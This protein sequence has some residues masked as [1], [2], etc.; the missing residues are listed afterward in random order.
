MNRPLSK[1]LATWILLTISRTLWGLP[2]GL[3][4]VIVDRLGA[5]GAIRWIVKNLPRYERMLKD[6]GPIR[7]H[8][9][10]AFVSM[11]NGCYYCAFAHARAFE[12][13]FFKARGALFPLDEH[14]MV[15]LIVLPD[16]ELLA[17]LDAAFGSAQLAEGPAL[18][19]RLVELMFR[20]AEGAGAEDGYLLHTI[21]MFE[22]LNFCGISTAVPLD[23]AHDPINKDHDLKARYAQARLTSPPP[24]EEKPAA[25]SG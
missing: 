12:L 19:R 20:G 4:P 21:R 13:H 9:A 24:A 16:P 3:M 15:D 8:L 22:V 7:G 5:F 6:L 11:L 10:A 17:R 18:F 1:R 2:A 23:G 25:A 14:Q